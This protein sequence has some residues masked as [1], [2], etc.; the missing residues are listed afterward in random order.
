MTV[1]QLK[2]AISL[3]R[4]LIDAQEWRETFEARAEPYVIFDNGSVSHKPRGEDRDRHGFVGDLE[5]PRDLAIDAMRFIEA[6]ATE[7]LTALGV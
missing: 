7:G 4:A 6:R 1:D 5:I 2:T 3:L